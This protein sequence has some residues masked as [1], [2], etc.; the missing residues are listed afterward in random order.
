MYASYIP[1][2]MY[3]IFGTCKEVT[4][5]PTAVNALMTYNY[6]GTLNTNMINAALTLGFFSGII[7]IGTGALNLGK[8]CR[9]DIF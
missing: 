2:F 3:A 9:W 6:V 4:I 5:G 8:I 1:G 7:E